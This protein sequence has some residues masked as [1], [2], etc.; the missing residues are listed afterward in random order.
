[1][2]KL[3]FISF[4][5]FGITAYAEAPSPSELIK[6]FESSPSTEAYQAIWDQYIAEG[7]PNEYGQL[8]TDIPEMTDAGFNSTENCPELIKKVNQALIN[9]YPSLALH[10]LALRCNEALGHVE[11]ADSEEQI[12]NIITELMLKDG[13]GKTYAEAYWVGH[14]A[15]VNQFMRLAGID[16]IDTHLKVFDDSTF[17]QSVL[18]E[19]SETGKQKFYS[20]NCSD[21]FN[22]LLVDIEK[23]KLTD[24]PIADAIFRS[25]WDMAIPVAAMAQAGISEAQI[26][27]GDL[28]ADMA[29]RFPEFAA[30]ALLYYSNASKSGSVIAKGRYASAIYVAQLEEK[31]SEATDYIVDAVESGYQFATYILTVNYLLGINDDKN[32]ELARQLIKLL[33]KTEPIEEVYFNIAEYLT[34]WGGALSNNK[35]GIEYYEKSAELGYAKAASELGRKYLYAE[36]GIE[37]STKKGLAWL[38]QAATMGDTDAHL[39]LSYAY[40]GHN[41]VKE[42]QDIAVFH[43][44]KAAELGDAVGY[45]N[46]ASAN[47]DPKSKFYNR[48][49]A[50]EQY[51]LGAEAG[52]KYSMYALALMYLDGKDIESD[53]QKAFELSE[54]LIEKNDNGGHQLQAIMYHNGLHFEKDIEKARQLYT[55]KSGNGSLTQLNKAILYL[56]NQRSYIYLTQDISQLKQQAKKDPL[57]ALQL[58]TY[59][60]NGHFVE[61]DIRKARKYFQRAGDMGLAVGFSKYAD[62]YSFSSTFFSSDAKRLKKNYLKAYEAGYLYAALPLGEYYLREAGSA[63]EYQRA[64]GFFSV[65][66]E[67]NQPRAH[68]LI[69]RMH[70]KGLGKPKNMQVALKHYEKAYELGNLDASKELG[71]LYAQIGI[72]GDIDKAIERYETS[73][74]AGNASSMYAMAVLYHGYIKSFLDLDKAVYWYTQAEEK[75]HQAAGV[76]LGQMYL[77]GD[78][79]EQNPAVGLLYLN[80]YARKN[81]FDAYFWLARA[82]QYGLGVEQNSEH[83]KDL[84]KQLVEVKHAKSINN[85]AYMLYQDSSTKRDYKKALSYFER[86]Q[87]QGSRTAKLNLGWM[88]EHGQ[89]TSM[90]INKAMDYYISAATKGS[91]CALY[92]LVL[93]AKN[94]EMSEPINLDKARQF[95]KETESRQ[96]TGSTIGTQD[97]LVKIPED[98]SGIN[99]ELLEL[100][101]AQLAGNTS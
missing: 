14:Y 74:S 35:L 98:L 58:G 90:N 73:A 39:K 86:S 36:G 61:Q 2:R 13:T 89:G 19:D 24:N 83:A 32:I 17:Y 12:V 52:N 40:F 69:G 34:E 93:I 29:S 101:Q 23:P 60:A 37:K 28:S 54:Q 85:Y 26:L 4:F 95:L 25:N 80:K 7:Q 91:S 78:G 18:F 50:A 16:I 31:Y 46:M 94:G 82:H 65:A 79:V 8:L 43:S 67:Q 15:D 76:K 56:P 42:D 45:Q 11:Q 66:A 96:T 22:A 99:N 97:C 49:L 47:N 48:A 33:A 87:K 100:E 20:F 71:W 81:N 3:S 5:L 27:M 72:Y 88:Y 30:A 55:E 10:Y 44:R 57:I 21:Y 1:M 68:L 51:K 70:E 63:Q 38:K 53:Y 6:Q 59:Y 84:Y 75:G 64:Y 62:T 9:H 92:R 41:G 77:T